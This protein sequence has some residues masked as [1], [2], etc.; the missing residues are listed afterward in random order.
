M[1]AFKIVEIR[2]ALGQIA[3]QSRSP[4]ENLARSLK[5][6]EEAAE[7][8]AHLII[9]PELFPFGIL[10]DRIKAKEAANLSKTFLEILK[11]AATGKKINI[12][13]GLP[14]LKNT[15]LLFNSLFCLT[16][17]GNTYRYDKLNLFPPFNED[18]IFD[19]GCVPVDVWIDTGTFEIGIGPQICFDIRFPEL[20]RTYSK[21]GC[22]L[23]V[24][25]ALWPL[26][27]TDNFITLL[28]AR[29]MENQCFVAAS[30][31]CGGYG[32]QELAGS[33]IVVAPDG[34]VLIKA[35]SEEGLF[36]EKINIERQKSIRTFFNSSWSQGLWNLPLEEKILEAKELKKRLCRIKKSGQKIVFTNGCFDI[37]HAGHVN[38]LKKARGLGDALVVGL[39][40]DSSIKKIKGKSRPVNPQEQRARV[41]AALSFVDFVVIFNEDTPQRLIHELRPDVLVKG[42]DWD[43]DKIVGARFVKSLGGRVERIPF[44]IN[45]STSKIIERVRNQKIPE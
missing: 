37:L 19:T 27:R 42:A 40:S 24:V 13:A 25:S 20:S 38:Y 23:L 35:K 31:A 14:F 22:H 34:T 4:E 18:K 41:L 12:F 7:K 9:F 1:E 21:R 28:K 36:F 5:Y 32:E 3:P 2:V 15:S 8:G 39:N 11:D 45:T 43:E 16:S 30:N 6:I 26:S 29:A 44:D 17:K 10:K 33:S